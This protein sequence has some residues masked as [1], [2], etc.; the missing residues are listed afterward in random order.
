MN[1]DQ[2][3]E[4]TQHVT[5]ENHDFLFNFANQ[6]TFDPSTTKFLK[7]RTEIKNGDEKTRKKWPLERVSF[8]PY[9]N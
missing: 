7:L 3:Y 1:N 9:L 5:D 8:F 2:S 6:S 4:S